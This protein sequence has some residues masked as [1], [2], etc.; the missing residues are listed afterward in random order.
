MIYSVQLIQTGD[1]VFYPE[2]PLCV[3]SC[4]VFAEY[5]VVCMGCG[6]LFVMR[7][8]FGEVILK[9]HL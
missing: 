3:A 1:N 4:Y 9:P 5:D 6:T 2:C 7:V 8:E